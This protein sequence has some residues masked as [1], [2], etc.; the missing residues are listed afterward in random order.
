MPDEKYFIGV[1]Y[2]DGTDAHAQVVVEFRSGEYFVSDLRMEVSTATT[3][4]SNIEVPAQLNRA[5]RRR[6]KKR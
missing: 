6:E 3:E 2:A 1:D 5:Q 4:S